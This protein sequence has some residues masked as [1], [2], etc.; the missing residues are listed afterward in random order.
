LGE[1]TVR[2]VR[3][4]ARFGY[5]GD[6]RRTGRSSKRIGTSTARNGKGKPRRTRISEA[7]R[8][9]R[10]ALT[11]RVLR[12]MMAHHGRQPDARRSNQPARVHCGTGRRCGVAS[13]ARCSGSDEA[14]YQCWVSDAD[15]TVM[16]ASSPDGWR[17]CLEVWR[18]RPSSHSRSGFL[19]VP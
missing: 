10:G 6:V 8:G 2:A 4:P 14:S 18:E 13:N 16:R 19:Q 7:D 15:V 1:P 12:A 3:S 17:I 11:H 5:V 9:L